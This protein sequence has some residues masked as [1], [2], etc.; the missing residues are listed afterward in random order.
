MAHNLGTSRRSPITR[1]EFNT[2]QLL[3]STFT[4]TITIHTLRI[5]NSPQSN[6]RAHDPQRPSQPWSQRPRRPAGTAPDSLALLVE[7][8]PP[9]VRG[10]GRDPRLARR[11]EGERGRHAAW[12]ALRW[13]L[14]PL[15]QSRSPGN[16]TLFLNATAEEIGR[17]ET[18]GNCSDRARRAPVGACSVL[19]RNCCRS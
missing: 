15:R 17:W 6:P 16:S 8:A 2:I 18:A 4:S 7:G 12:S 5:Q 1:F 14:A 11:S 10:P 9:G 3:V 19:L 13:L